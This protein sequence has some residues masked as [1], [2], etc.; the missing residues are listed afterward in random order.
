MKVL[1]IDHYDSF[2]F[3]LI[4][5][6]QTRSKKI[7]IIRVCYDQ[8]RTLEKYIRNPLPVVLSPGPCSPKEASTTMNFVSSVFD[9]VPILGVCLGEQILGQFAGF[10]MGRS[11]KPLHGSCKKVFLSDRPGRLMKGFDSVLE[12]ACYHSLVLRES[13]LVSP[14]WRVTARC[15]FGEIMAI[16]Y[17]AGSRWLTAG[18]QFHPESFLSKQMGT[19]ADNWIQSAF[20][21]YVERKK[22]KA[23]MSYKSLQEV[24][25]L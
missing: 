5:W 19:I 4:D 24:S 12:V 14:G 2:T 23:E 16:E 18:V 21:W 20:Q 25:Q 6:L 9:Q 3:N 22:S 17:E 8:V 1:Y 13:E 7:E 11:E 10:Q 15:E